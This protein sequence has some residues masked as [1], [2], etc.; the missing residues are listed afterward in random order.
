MSAKIQPRLLRTEDAA[1]Y[2]A[3]S[4]SSFNRDVAPHCRKLNPS[5][6]RVAWLRD[7]L[8]AWIDWLAGVKAGDTKPAPQAQPLNPLD[9]YL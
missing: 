7:D 4:V 8:D 3:V 1:E 5:G 9:E 6:V 2:C